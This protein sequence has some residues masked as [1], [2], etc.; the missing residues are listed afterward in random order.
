MDETQRRKL[1]AKDFLIKNRKVGYILLF[2]FF[3]LFFLYFAFIYFYAHK[4]TQINNIENTQNQ[5]ENFLGS[6][7]PVFEASD[8]RD[9][10]LDN[11]FLGNFN[12]KNQ[13]GES[14]EDLSKL[15]KIEDKPILGFVVFENPISIKNYIKD[16]PKICAEKLEVVT[17][18]E[19]KSTSVLTLQNILKNTP[20]FEETPDTSVLD[21]S[22]REKL[23]IFQKKYAGILYKNKESKEPTR[24]IDKETVHFLNLLC[25]FDKE[26]KDDF[27]QVPT[28]RYVLKETREIFDYNTDT[29]EKKQV[30]AK[31]AT[32]TEDMILSKDGNFAVFRKEVNGGIDSIFYN[33]KTKSITHLEKNVST[34]DFTDKNLLIYGT[35]SETGLIIKNYN[36]IGN[37]VKRIATIP[38]NEWTLND[39]NENEIA[40]NSKPSAFAEGIYMIL[41]TQTG[42]LRQ[43]AGPLTGLSLQK[44]NIPD[45]TI[46]S[47]GGQ[48]TAKTLLLNNKTRNIGDFGINTFAEKC[49]QNIF[50]DGIFCAVP[51]ILSGNFIYPDDWYKGKVYTSDI[52]VY[53]SLS[54]TSTKII[55][56]LENR[57]LS[58]INLNITKNGIFFIDENTF[59]L[60][61]LEL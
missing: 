39:L 34:L 9:N 58:I 30:D 55:S 41:N 59:S 23:Y 56:S 20:G 32:G 4:K 49:S 22:T 25:G 36:Y 40:I 51:K 60:F 48:G 6:L 35:P 13:N 26:N 5:K 57:N 54:G 12:T 27:V 15:V 52:L 11:N 53:K 45:F 31:T 16:K 18:K 42:K 47:T 17:K 43:L 29:K 46:L 37:S 3:S 21:E 1:S 33:I 38:L 8:T 19:E 10:E 7:L 24:L 61:S 2:L 28:L 14:G 44:T 50:A